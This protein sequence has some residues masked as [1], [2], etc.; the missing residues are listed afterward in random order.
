M[1]RCQIVGEYF[2]ERFGI[3][4]IVSGLNFFSFKKDEGHRKALVRIFCVVESR[5]Y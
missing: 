2:F 5:C 4:V 3:V 1:M